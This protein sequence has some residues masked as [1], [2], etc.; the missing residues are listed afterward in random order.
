MPLSFGYCKTKISFIALVAKYLDTTGYA[1]Q[2]S[3][4]CNQYLQIFKYGDLTLLFINI[5]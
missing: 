1:G 2:K 5:E 3:H 4:E